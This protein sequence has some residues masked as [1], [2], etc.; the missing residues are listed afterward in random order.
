M[1]R[2]EREVAQLVAEGLSNRQIADRLV[3]SPRTAESH[4]Q[5]VLRKLGVTSR[6][7]VVGW[8]AR[9]DRSTQA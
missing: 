8:V 7:A 2:R 9:Q 4:V 5:A 1:T 3:I 6:T